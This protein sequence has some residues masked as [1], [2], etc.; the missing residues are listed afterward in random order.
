MIVKLILPSF[1]RSRVPRP[2]ICL[3]MV[4]EEMVLSKTMT[5][6]ILQSTPVE[7]SSEVV[8]MTGYFALT[9]IK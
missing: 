7:R 4:M 9:E 6:V 8:A 1:S 3:N 2:T 5:F